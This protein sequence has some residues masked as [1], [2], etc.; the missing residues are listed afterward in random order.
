MPEREDICGGPSDGQWKVPGTK[1]ID[2]VDSL[3]FK[4]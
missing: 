2:M 1:V 4:R 3:V